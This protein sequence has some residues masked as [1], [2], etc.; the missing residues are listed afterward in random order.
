[1]NEVDG[2]GIDEVFMKMIHEFQ[3]VSFHSSGDRNVI[4]ERQVDDVFA[5]T[6][7]AGMRAHRDTEPV[8]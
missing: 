3:D 5:Q 4:D 6:H 1:M 2:A 8:T 7:A